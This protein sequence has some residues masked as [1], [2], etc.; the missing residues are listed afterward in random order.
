M[1][2]RGA[3]MRPGKA[4]TKQGAAGKSS[5]PERNKEKGSDDVRRHDRGEREPD[6]E[7]EIE[8]FRLRAEWFRR[9]HGDTSGFIPPERRLQAIDH[10]SRMGRVAWS[11]L[12]PVDSPPKNGFGLTGERK[13]SA[14]LYAVEN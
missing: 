9:Y 1:K 12:D 8:N 14:K 11:D 3:G 10:A 13:N 2:K 5:K 4:A 7:Q 6:A